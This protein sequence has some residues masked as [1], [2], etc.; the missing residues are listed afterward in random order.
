V[1]G[2]S[3]RLVRVDQ[4]MAWVLRAS[5]SCRVAYGGAERATRAAWLRCSRARLPALP[6]L[7]RERPSARVCS[8]HAPGD[9]CAFGELLY[10][11]AIS[12]KLWGPWTNAQSHGRLLV[13][14]Q[15]AADKQK[16]AEHAKEEKAAGK[17][18]GPTEEVRSLAVALLCLLCG[19]AHIRV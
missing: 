1:A 9:G 5:W 17:A 19:A 11:L 14:V 10:P 2:S 18:A 13:T 8:R 16:A 6:G 3:V 4:A 7:Q 12:G 15:E